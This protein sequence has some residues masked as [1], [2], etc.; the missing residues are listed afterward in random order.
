M[1]EQ[2]GGPLRAVVRRLRASD[3]ADLQRGCY[4]DQS[5]D[6]VQAYADWC[7]RQMEVGRLVRLVVEVGG[8]AVANG[9]LTLQG[10]QAEIGSL[11]VAPAYRRRGIGGQLLRALIAKARRHGVCSLVLAASVEEPWLRAWYEREGFGHAR[12]RVLPREERVWVLH[13]ALQENRLG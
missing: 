2:E 5:L 10:E 11:V 7:L 6:M 12:E 9:Q 8:R 4:P 1:E 13:M 3:A